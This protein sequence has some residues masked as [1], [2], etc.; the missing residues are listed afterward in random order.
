MVRPFMI[1][2]K[3]FPLVLAGPLEVVGLGSSTFLLL[4]GEDS[5]VL[6]VLVSGVELNSEHTTDSTSLQPVLSTMGAVKIKV[7]ECYCFNQYLSTKIPTNF[8]Q[9]INFLIINTC[10]I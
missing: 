5:G 6:S 4:V 3:S 2:V 8:Q 7:G 9:P 10:N 1:N